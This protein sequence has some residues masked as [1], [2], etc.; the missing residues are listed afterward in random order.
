MSQQ[1]G[2]PARTPG[3]STWW[4]A[5][6]AAL[7]AF[8]V[9]ASS[10][11]VL[12]A[13]QVI[14]GGSR[15]APTA[16]RITNLGAKQTPPTTAGAAASATA[17]AAEP[18]TT[19]LVTL[20][21][22]RVVDSRLGARLRAG[23]EVKVPLPGLPRGSTAVL[24]E[25]SVVE[26]SGPGKVTLIGGAEA[27]PVLRVPG[28]G[29]QT[30]ATVVARLGTEPGLKARIEG[31]G[32]LVVT[33]AGAFRPADTARA[34]RFLPVPAEQALEL[35]PGQDGNEATIHPEKLELAGTPREEVGAL[36]LSFQADV[37]V[38]GGTV[39]VGPS[40][41][42]LDH[43]VFWGATESSDRTRRGFLIVPV[44]SSGPLRLYYHAGTKLTVNVVGLVTGSKA[45]PESAG[46]SVPV[47]PKTLAPVTL[48][49]GG[50]VD[51]DLPD[52]ADA[53]AALVT[54]A[55]TPKGERPRSV[56]GLL[57]VR[58]GSVRLNGPERASVTLT[59]RLLIR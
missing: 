36:L 44:S 28:R 40:W 20:K 12:L 55:T 9:V 27:T 33:L 25:V 58:E 19:R 26:A 17:A 54:T 56:L 14:G 50:R 10:G 13:T 39:A 53:K 15:P 8:T 43:Q 16:D 21:P 30:S 4:P 11:A 29:A 23:A 38:H 47:A 18:V 49:A 24:L 35:F 3:R 59:P 57:D 45:A 41:Q 5:L 7:I 34:G 2:W 51:V 48:P 42:H 6:W 22:R 32:H 1:P 31:G 46:L 52:A 37:G